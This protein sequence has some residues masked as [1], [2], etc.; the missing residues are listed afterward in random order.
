MSWVLSFFHVNCLEFEPTK[1]VYHVPKTAVY[2]IMYNSPTSV[3]WLLS[4]TICIELGRYQVWLVLCTKSA[5]VT[6][7]FIFKYIECLYVEMKY[8]SIK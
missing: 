3:A 1:C 7:N 8:L 2:R 5:C 4:K 6:D